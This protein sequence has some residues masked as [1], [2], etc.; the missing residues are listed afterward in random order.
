[1]NRIDKRFFRPASI[2]R[3]IVVVY[4]RQQRFSQQA[5]QDMIDGLLRGCS[6]VGE[7]FWSL[8]FICHCNALL[9]GM[10]VNDTSPLVTWQNGQGR[11]AEVKIFFLMLITMTHETL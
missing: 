6:D 9:P 4:E 8:C 11:I 2:E 7:S 1:L 3:W 10:K 5:A